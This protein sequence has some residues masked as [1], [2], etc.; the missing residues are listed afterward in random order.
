MN[1]LIKIPCSQYIIVSD[2]KIAEGDYY[3]DGSYQA[4]Q[5]TNS[6]Q[7]WQNSNDDKP[8]HEKCFKVTHATFTVDSLSDIKFIEHSKCQDIERGYN[9]EELSQQLYGTL[10]SGIEAERRLIFQSG[11]R[12]ALEILGDKKFNDNDLLSFESFVS[13]WFDNPKASFDDYTKTMPQILD[14]WKSTQLITEWMVELVDGK[15]KLV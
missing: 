11:F 10:D 12:K 8:G 6:M 1:K 7:D 14:K 2:E 13:K 5:A 4:L 3:I 9:I 15:L